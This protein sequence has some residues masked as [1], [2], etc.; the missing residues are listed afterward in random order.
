MVQSEIHNKS[1]SVSV[2]GPEMFGK[3]MMDNMKISRAI[4]VTF[5]LL[6]SLL[7]VEIVQA[8][9][10]FASSCS[11]SDVVLAI[12]SSEKGDIVVLPEGVCT[13]SDNISISNSITVTGSGNNETVIINNY[14]SNNGSTLSISG[15]SG[16][17]V[18]I[19]NIK[20]VKG[21]GTS[22]AV[23]ASNKYN[24]ELDN[25]Y[26]ENFGTAVQLY[27]VELSTGAVFH[28]NTLVTNAS[29]AE[30]IHIWGDQSAENSAWENPSKLGT[31]SMWFIED[32]TFSKTS[33][34]NVSG[35]AVGMFYGSRVV[36][37]HNSIEGMY[38]FDAHEGN[39]GGVSGRR[40]AR[41][42]EVYNND[43]VVN[44]GDAI[45]KIIQPRAGSGVIYNNVLTKI[46]I[47]PSILHLLAWKPYS[48]LYGCAKNCDY[49]AYDQIGRGKD[50]SS[51]P[52]YEWNNLL[53]NENVD[54]KIQGRP[55]DPTCE[56]ACGPEPL[57]GDFGTETVDWYND[58][59]KPGYS[60]FI[61]PYPLGSDNIAPA[62]PSFL[63]FE[64][65]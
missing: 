3:G 42:W 64:S 2:H 12:N 15:N 14:D 40:G 53:N 49:P 19:T 35:Y 25:L 5:L 58:L 7:S 52:V 60:A 31:H 22:R 4:F 34:G 41:E 54:F 21:T 24:H 11:E 13:W 50:Q 27:H 29:N 28:N 30:I 55:Y 32:N 20:F 39:Y 46:G 47:G 56:A 65:N 36:I 63:N 38:I 57:P 16:G 23:G 37:R 33:F 8:G 1:R 26:F 17:P 6:Y 44:S 43:W 61:Y 59:Q 51:Q 48:P 45:D 62:P 18:R 10:I 9:M